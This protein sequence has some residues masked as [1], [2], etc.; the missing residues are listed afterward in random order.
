VNQHSDQPREEFWRDLIARFNPRIRAYC[1][2][3]R[4]SN[5]DVEELLWDV[6]Q[7]AAASECTLA[8]ST[9]HW[10]ILQLHARRV[11]ARRSRWLR[12]ERTLYDNHGAL[13]NDSGDVTDN[14]QILRKWAD[15]LLRVLP[16]KQR[17][18]IE[19]RCRWGWPY[20]A[21]AA[22]L[23]SAEPTARVHVGRGL[24]HLRVLARR[25]PPPRSD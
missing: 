5:D 6:W 3:L 10:P 15:Q 1:R 25:F 14:Q 13:Q 24:R 2:T 11:C 18:A 7:E 20:W 4:C 23:D 22:A 17:T 16:E 12:R 9:D 19:Y 21:V 8:A